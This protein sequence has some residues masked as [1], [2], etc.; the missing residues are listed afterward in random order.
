MDRLILT[1]L[2]LTSGALVA[3]QASVPPGDGNTELVVDHGAS[4]H[5]LEGAFAPLADRVQASFPEAND[6]EWLLTTSV[7]TP[8]GMIEVTGTAHVEEIIIEPLL[9]GSLQGT[10]V[11]STLQVLSPVDEPDCF[12]EQS[13][14]EAIASFTIVPA[15]TKN[16]ELVF[17]AEAP[18]L[19]DISQGFIPE[20]P[21]VDPETG[22]NPVNEALQQLSDS[23]VAHASS[24]LGL[25]LT[26]SLE[27]GKVRLQWRTP[28][29]TLADWSLGSP[30]SSP[31]ET[32]LLKDGA[33]LTAPLGLRMGGPDHPCTPSFTSPP[34]LM[35]ELP[36][37]GNQFTGP[38]DGEPTHLFQVHGSEL[39]GIARDAY[40]TGFFCH[41]TQL[42][43]TLRLG[44]LPVSDSLK[45][46]FGHD[47]PIEIRIQPILPP[48]VN[49]GDAGEGG[50]LSIHILFGRIRIEVYALLNESPIRLHV[51]E[52]AASVAL[53]QQA[54]SSGEILPLALRNVQTSQSNFSESAFGPPPGESEALA[55]VVLETVFME[56]LSPVATALSWSPFVL[57]NALNP[58]PAFRHQ[59]DYAVFPYRVESELP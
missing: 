54:Q 7:E 56:L 42:P 43:E 22:F 15:L 26:N 48:K 50:A 16:Q 23:I 35:P 14:P 51:M 25:F 2:L 6:S 57:T 10:L 32:V 28:G 33:G 4:I 21:C 9:D 5:L 36:S 12:P 24:A 34:L 44:D 40:R 38:L 58:L 8:D 47:A 30:L 39:E 20:S 17:V 1:A 52:S 27:V 59:S 29:G 18:L 53:G 49:L 41:R 55:Q 31:E 19:L 3:C 45:E 13:V 46:L 37:F 11:L